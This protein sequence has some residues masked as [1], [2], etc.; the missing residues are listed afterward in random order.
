MSAVQI[1]VRALTFT[2][3]ARLGD[4]CDSRGCRSLTR[5]AAPWLCACS[6]CYLQVAGTGYIFGAYLACAWPAAGDAK[7]V[8]D[9]SG[10]SFL[11]SLVNK[12]GQ[13]VRFALHDKERALQVDANGIRFGGCKMEGDKQVGYPNFA[14]MCGGRLASDSEGNRAA[15][16]EIGQCAFQPEGGAVCDQTFLAGSQFF[17]AEEIEVYQ[18]QAPPAGGAAASA[19]SSSSAAA[20]AGSSSISAAAAAAASS[21]SS[22]TAAVVTPNADSP[23]GMEIDL[24][25]YEPKAPAASAPAGAAQ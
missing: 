13:A 24:E 3:A 20:A 4:V 16:I 23:T 12:E 8:S 6:W 19:S 10:R 14:L 2:R 11:F 21:L 7:V 22:P 18:L 5:F 17:G 9:P 25:S 15:D 1:K